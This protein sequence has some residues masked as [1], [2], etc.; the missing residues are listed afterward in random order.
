MKKILNKFIHW[1][2]VA[3]LASLIA[4]LLIMILA[5][6]LGSGDS[7]RESIRGWNGDSVMFITFGLP[8]VWGFI[9]TC[10]DWAVDKLNSKI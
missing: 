8:L 1:Y 7:L 6:S 2:L 9:L 5:I 4:T 10:F 3:C